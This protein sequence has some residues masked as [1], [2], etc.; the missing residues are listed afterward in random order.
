MSSAQNIDKRNNNQKA[1]WKQGQQEGPFWVLNEHLPMAVVA[2]VACF[3]P[4][5]NALNPCLAGCTT[6]SLEAPVCA[7][8]RT[9]AVIAGPHSMDVLLGIAVIAVLEVDK[10]LVIDDVAETVDVVRVDRLAL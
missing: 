4:L 7:A 3:C 1:D 8:G 6:A 10:P 2:M 9:D 5:D